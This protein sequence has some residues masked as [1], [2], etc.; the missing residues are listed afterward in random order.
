[1][2]RETRSKVGAGRAAAIALAGATI[3]VG[4][5]SQAAAMKMMM[6]QSIAMMPLPPAKNVGLQKAMGNAKVDVTRGTVKLAVTL[7]PGTS[8][9]AGTI[10]EGWL[11]TAGMK[12]ASPNDEKY[13]PAFGKK[14][15][16]MKADQVPY[17]L[18]TGRLYRKGNSRTYVGSF[19]IDNSLA[20]YGAV[21]VTLESDG[22]K[23]TYDP[24]PGTPLVAGM[25]K[26]DK[27]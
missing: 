19:Q 16:S 22:N 2:K 7:A 10:L 5:V 25:I 21:A 6:R 20:P 4:A 18:S 3:V 17:A 9:P 27:M 14:E 11:S 12:T 26:H 23:G 24:R 13:G 1:M 15:L 8:L